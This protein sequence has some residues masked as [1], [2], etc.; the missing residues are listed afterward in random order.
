M[1]SLLGTIRR[2][3]M[4]PALAQTTFAVRG[5]DPAGAEQQELLERIGAIF[6]T[7]YGAGMS[8]GS[9]QEIDDELGRIDRPFRGFAYEGCAMALTIRD[10]ITPWPTRWIDRYLEGPARDH[11]YMTH[12][13]TGWAMARLPHPLWGA[14]V[15]ADP[16]LRWLALDGLGFHQAYFKTRRY[17]GAHFRP[18][19]YRGWP[20]FP[21][22]THRAVDQGIGRA[23]WFINGADPM[24]VAR[25]IA[26]FPPHRHSDLFSGAGLASCYAGGTDA[27]GLTAFARLA[28]AHVP[29]VRQAAA[30]AAKT[31]L[32]TNLVTEHTEMAVKVYCDSSVE[33]AAAVTDEELA[34]LPG[35]GELPAYELWRQRIALRFTG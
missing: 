27:T 6:L 33:Q 3:T 12:I 23:L 21:D 18:E 1:P 13:G 32:A 15:P 25:C 28:G 4:T 26:G 19:R 31:R 8:A 2:R 29:A 35:D 11:V 5:F 22:Y 30:F 20:W 10:A 17:V 24:R 7:G 14:V 34:S 9:I 16:L